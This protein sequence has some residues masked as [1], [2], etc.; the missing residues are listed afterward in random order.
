M[1]GAQLNVLPQNMVCLVRGWQNAV[2]LIQQRL[3]KVNAGPK[4]VNQDGRQQTVFQR[5]C[6]QQVPKYK[7]LPSL[8]INQNRD[9]IESVFLWFLTFQN[10]NGI[11]V[12]VFYWTIYVHF[13]NINTC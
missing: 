12:V 11:S 8:L 4:K 7:I 6:H 2:G 13:I 10:H 1:F 5:F 3:I 9:V